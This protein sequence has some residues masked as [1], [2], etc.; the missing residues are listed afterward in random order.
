MPDPFLEKFS[1]KLE[2]FRVEVIDRLARIETQHDRVIER[3]DRVNGTIDKQSETL[4]EHEKKITRMR[5]L[6]H[7]FA[8]VA[9]AMASFIVH[10]FRNW[11]GP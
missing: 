1:D 5:A 9:A 8:T 4:R 7:L 10:R 6:V 2:D 11:F 3:L